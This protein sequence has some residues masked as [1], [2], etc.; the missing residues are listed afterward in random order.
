MLELGFVVLAA[1]V[2]SCWEWEVRVLVMIDGHLNQ[3]TVAAIEAENVDMI[4]NGC[5]CEVGDR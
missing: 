3:L 2:I 5:W 1:A 4:G